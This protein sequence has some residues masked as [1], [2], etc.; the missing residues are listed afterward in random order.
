[1]K[2]SLGPIDIRFYSG[3]NWSNLE[4]AFVTARKGGMAQRETAVKTGFKSDHLLEVFGEDNPTDTLKVGDTTYTGKV[5]AGIDG[6][7]HVI[8]AE[9]VAARVQRTEALKAAEKAVDRPADDGST[10]AAA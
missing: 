4:F 6:D 1:M 7:K 8:T 2:I 9:Q 3:Q 5:V 10:P